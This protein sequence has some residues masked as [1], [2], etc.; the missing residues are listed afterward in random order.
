ML[1]LQ[2]AGGILL[3]FAILWIINFVVQN[4][5]RG[6]LVDQRY[7]FLNQAILNE[8]SKVL[9]GKS[10]SEQKD[11]GEF[12]KRVFEDRNNARIAD[13]LGMHG[14]D[15]MA[16]MTDDEFRK[17]VEKISVGVASLVVAKKYAWPPS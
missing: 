2:V 14:T 12:L 1:M 17:Y 3:A 11:A 13:Q 16:N 8:A 7:S 15:S 4:K 5:T 10:D 6:R 9:I